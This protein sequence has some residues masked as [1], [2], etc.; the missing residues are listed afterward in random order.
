[1]SGAPYAETNVIALDVPIPTS[2][3][4]GLVVAAG[5]GAPRGAA[6]AEQAAVDS[7]PGVGFSQGIFTDDLAKSRVE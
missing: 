5:Y 1:M 3:V 7:E 4:A 2:A 6:R